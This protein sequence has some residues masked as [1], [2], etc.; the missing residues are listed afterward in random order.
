MNHE[1][2]LIYIKK[3]IRRR[4]VRIIPGCIL[5]MLGLA[6]E[7]ISEYSGFFSVLNNKYIV[8]GLILIGVAIMI[9]ELY[10]LVLLLDKT[11]KLSRNKN[12]P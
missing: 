3:Q 2:E 12:T 1:T 4:I 9:V 7:F 6:R 5:F 11:Q 8:D 10:F